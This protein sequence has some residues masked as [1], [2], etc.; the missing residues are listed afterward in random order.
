MPVDDVFSYRTETRGKEMTTENST[1][2]DVTLRIPGDWQSRDELL[3]RLPDG[4]EVF[5]DELVLPDG[6]KIEFAS[7]PADRQFPVVFRTALRRPAETEELRLID[8]YTANV[9]LNGPGGSLESAQTMMRAGA[10]IIEAGG[11]G[12]FIDNSCLS[13]GG[14]NW[15]YMVE[16]SSSDSIS[17]AFVGIVRSK[18]DVW[19]VGFHVLGFPEIVMR[20]ADADA[21]EQM[22]I[23][24]IRY[25][26]AADREVGDGHII[27]DEEGP[28]FTMKQEPGNDPRLPGAMRN[29]WGRLRMV[30]IKEIAEQ[31]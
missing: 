24:M 7:T 11:V 18:P 9:L 10:A 1:A 2:V 16:E 23:E 15:Q 31:N 30:S 26:C 19:T 20:R 29:P 28:R 14:A 25:V 12:V 21:D 3:E 4:Y 6:T 27:A 5:G 8:R 17:F 13:H 22:I